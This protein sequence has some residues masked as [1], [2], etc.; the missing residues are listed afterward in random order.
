[1]KIPATSRQ[2]L[3]LTP[4]GE[5]RL[6]A[7]GHG[8]SG[9][10]FTSNQR[11]VPDAAAGLPTAPDDPLLQRA[12]QQLDEFFARQRNRFDLPLDLSAGTAFQQAVWTVLQA[13]GFGTTCSYG[14]VAQA[15]AR[16]SAVRAVGVAIGRNPVSLIVPCHRVIGA[17]G[18]LTGY[19]GGIDR[20]VALLAL[21]R[22]DVAAPTTARGA[23]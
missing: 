1:M 11:H 8:L 4:L 20:K 7:T 12:A 10:W 13:I 19:G 14:A 22:G 2:L 9:A 17:N 23:A 6:V 3:L 16:P 15:I 18:T 21:E 5:M